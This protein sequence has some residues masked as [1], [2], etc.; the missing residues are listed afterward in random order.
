VARRLLRRRG[1]PFEEVRGESVADFRRMLRRRTGAA[2]V[3][4]V[5]IDDRPIGGAD[6]LLALDRSGALM[7]RIRH[8]PFPAV[9]IRRR[10]SLLRGRYEVRVVERDGEVLAGARARSE[11]EAES[12]ARSFRG[13][14]LEPA[15]GSGCR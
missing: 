5:V 13:E 8:E 11:D 7:P 3:P 14:F 4:Q 10:L 6:A 12:V 1:I 2:T 15:L 9:V